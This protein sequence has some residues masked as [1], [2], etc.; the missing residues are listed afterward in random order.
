MPIDIPGDWRDIE[1]W[2]RCMAHRRWSATKKWDAE[3]E[4]KPDGS[5]VYRLKEDYTKFGAIFLKGWY[6]DRDIAD[7]V[8]SLEKIRITEEY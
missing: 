4:T 8:S 6:Y 7:P 2:E 1:D 5:I 3:G